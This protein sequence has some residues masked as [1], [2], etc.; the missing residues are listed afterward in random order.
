M[1][2]NQL[3]LCLLYP[4]KFFEMEHYKHSREIKESTP[5]WSNGIEFSIGS[6]LLNGH[7]DAD[8]T[9]FSV[10]TGADIG[11]RLDTPNS[12]PLLNMFGFRVR[13]VDVTYG[14]N[15]ISSDERSVGDHLF[16]QKRIGAEKFNIRLKG[17][18]EN[19]VLLK[20]KRYVVP[21]SIDEFD[22]GSSSWVDYHKGIPL[23]S[24]EYFAPMGKNFYFCDDPQYED[25]IESYYYMQAY[26]PN[27]TLMRDN[28]GPSEM[29]FIKVIRN[30]ENFA[31]F[32][33]VFEDNTRVYLME[34]RVATETP[35]IKLYQSWGHLV[36]VDAEPS[37]VNKI[38]VHNIDGSYPGTIKLPSRDRGR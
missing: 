21:Y 17:L 13:V 29:K 6:R 7:R 2:P 30:T 8:S 25:F 4:E 27:T 10:R 18:F 3:R 28:F 22:D 32:Q 36:D 12:I 38:M 31:Q 1:A 26:V 37:A 34:D 14:W 9:V 24:F 15:S 23:P 20:A 5:L 33:K 16:V 11:G 19:C 35:D